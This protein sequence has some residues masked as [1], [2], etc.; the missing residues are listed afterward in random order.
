MQAGGLVKRLLVVTD[1][2]E[3]LERPRHRGRGLRRYAPSRSIAL[4][5]WT[6]GLSIPSGTEAC[7]AVPRTRRRSAV[8]LFSPTAIVTSRR[9]SASSS[10]LPPPSLSA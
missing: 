2:A 9:P 7:P 5:R 1:D 6:S 10:K 4:A 8:T 3:H